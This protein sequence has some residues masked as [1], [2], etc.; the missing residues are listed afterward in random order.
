M[1]FNANVKVPVCS[2]NVHF[3]TR[4]AI[5]LIYPWFPD[6]MNSLFVVFAFKQ[7]YKIDRSYHLPSVWLLDTFQRLVV[8][9]IFLAFS[10]HLIPPWDW[11]RGQSRIHAGLLEQLIS[12]GITLTEF[13]AEFDLVSLND[14]LIHRNP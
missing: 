1:F 13:N 10:R 9:H 14:H 4:T 2:L 11:R 3:A 8:D 12:I 7:I 6:M 5:Q